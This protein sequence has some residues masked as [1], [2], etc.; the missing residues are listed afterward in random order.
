MPVPEMFIVAG[1][2]GGGKSTVFSLRNFTNRIFNADDRAAELN[3]GSY[4]A[5]PLAVRH[6]V[7]R[8]FE[9]FIRDNIAA[10]KSFALETTMRSK[11][12]FEQAKLAKSAG[13]HVFMTYVAVDT[14]ERHVERVT[15]RA[16]LGGHAA[17]ETTLRRIYQSSLENLPLALEPGQSGIDEVRIFD[18]SG[19]QQAPR[20]ALEARHG[21]V[22]RLANEFPAWLR[23]VLNWTESDLQKIRSR[24]RKGEG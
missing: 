24:L 6:R 2:P 16:L 4:F 14:F 17:S 15:Q 10:H 5:I 23:R 1:P 21:S 9:I 11:I 22:T 13:F 18:N 7:N 12:T 20:L 3:G 19:F 8:E